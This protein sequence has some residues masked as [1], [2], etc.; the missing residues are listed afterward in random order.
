MLNANVKSNFNRREGVVE[1]PCIK[2]GLFAY[3]APAV[4]V[5]LYVISFKNV[6]D[7]S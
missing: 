1:C 5:R 6:Y 3:T 2:Y 4:E 7:F